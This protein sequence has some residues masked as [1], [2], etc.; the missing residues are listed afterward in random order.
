[1]NR[2]AA[3]QQRLF[4]ARSSRAGSG[5]EVIQILKTR[6]QSVVARPRSRE[7]PGTQPLE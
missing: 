4:P 3:E 1:M 5:G 6:S 7:E 2:R